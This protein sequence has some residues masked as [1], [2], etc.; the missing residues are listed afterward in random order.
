MASAVHP[1]P[2]S[3]RVP[4]QCASPEGGGPE[5]G[6]RTIRAGPGLPVARGGR[7]GV[8]PGGREAEA[9]SDEALADPEKGIRQVV[10][11]LRKGNI[12]KRTWI[13]FHDDIYAGEWIGVW[14]D[15]PPPPE[16]VK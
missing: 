7:R 8:E 16:A 6:T 12:A 11:V 4:L 3:R 14:E 10:E 2:E 5:S 1:A 15:T 13:L 9:R